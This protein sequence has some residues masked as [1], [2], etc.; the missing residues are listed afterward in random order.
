MRMRNPA[1]MKDRIK[2]KAK[3]CQMPP[4]VVLHMYVMERFLE[5]LSKSEHRDRFILKGGYLLYTMWGMAE[6]TTSDIDLSSKS[7]NAETE[8]IERVFKEICTVDVD[9]DF[10]IAVVKTEPVAEMLDHPGVRVFMDARYGVLERFYADVVPNEV[11]VPEEVEHGIVPILDGELIFVKAYRLETVIA[12]KIYVALT[13][14][15]N[16]TRMRDYYDFFVIDHRPDLIY[17]LDDLRLA[18]LYIFRSRGATRYLDDSD[19]IMDMVSSDAIM[20]NNWMNHQ[21]THAYA[22]GI[23]FGDA[24]E[25]ARRLMSLAKTASGK[26]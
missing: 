15:V 2:N 20:A 23:S 3:E 6:R 8:E 11:L 1:Q 21:R 25:S 22:R 10:E 13:R 14:G 5:R 4:D 24:C 19:S 7:L 18:V 17:R 9:D 16:N 26:Q 12:E